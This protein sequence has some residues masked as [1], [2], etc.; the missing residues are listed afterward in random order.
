MKPSQII[1]TANFYKMWFMFALS[2][3]SGLMVIAHAANITKIQASW[4]GGFIVVIVLAVFNGIGRSFGGMLSDRIGRPNLMRLT[5]VVQ[6]ANMFVFALYT[7]Y[8]I[9]LVGVAVT[10]MCYGACM[11]VF[12]A[13]TSD[14]YG[15]EY[16]GSNYGLVFTSW[17]IAGVLGP[18]PGALIFDATKSFSA[19]Y[20]L[21]GAM[22]TAALIIAFTL[23]VPRK[24]AV[25]LS[26]Q[27]G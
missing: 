26:T 17:G 22:A 21:A 5:F 4:E 10:G 11:V 13:L 27:R 19:A 24:E 16:F 1:K 3:A 23:N 14:L 25:V 7:N 2:A 8:A 9:L 15:M 6:A 12:S 20:L 18:I